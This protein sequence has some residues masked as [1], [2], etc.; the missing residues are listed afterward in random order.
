M[1][2][3]N[4][5]YGTIK[6]HCV[7]SA[8]RIVTVQ[9]LN[10]GEGVFFEVIDDRNALRATVEYRDVKGEVNIIPHNAQL[11]KRVAEKKIRLSFPEENIWDAERQGNYLARLVNGK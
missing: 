1:S 9:M 3:A 6:Q 7:S 11:I 8:G 5:L 4:V 2:K 10:D